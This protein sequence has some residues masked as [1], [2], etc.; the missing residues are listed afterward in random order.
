MNNIFLAGKAFIQHAIWLARRDGPV[1]FGYKLFHRKL[2]D[3]PIR[4]M[5]T[6][7]VEVA[8]VI[9]SPQTQ[10]L[11]REYPRLANIYLGAYLAK[12]FSKKIRREILKEHYTYLSRLVSTEFFAQVVRNRSMLWHR[13]LDEKQYAITL[14]F[15]LRHHSEGDLLLSFEENSVPLYLISFTIAPG[16]MVGSTAAQVMLIAR[17]QGVP[18]QFDVI[19][20]VSKLFGGVPLPHLLV[21]AAQGASDALNIG[22]IAAVKHTEQ[23]MTSTDLRVFF[24]YDAFWQSF[25][26]SETEKFYLI[27]VQVSEKPDENIRSRRTRI[28]RQAKYEI[29]ASAKSYFVDNVLRRD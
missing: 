11:L 13:T 29:T 14:A 24:N 10:A 2:W 5:I 26:G 1:R 6:G 8:R 12:S 27:P 9:S 18:G 20:R 25:L 23:L 4:S 19:R 15:N 22:V 16:T 3:E 21:A 28:K 17:V 7:H